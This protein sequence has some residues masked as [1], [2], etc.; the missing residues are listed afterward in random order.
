MHRYLFLLFSVFVLFLASCNNLK[1]VPEDK[2]L[3]DKVR[4]VTEKGTVKSNDLSLNLYQVPNKHFLGLFNLSLSWYN[5][6]GKDTTKFIN[7]VFRKIGRAPVI[8]DSVQTERSRMVM[9]NMLVNKGYFEA[10]IEKKVEIKNRRVYVQYLVNTNKPYLIR[11]Y[12]FIPSKDT[13]SQLIEREMSSSNIRPG[14]LLNSGKLDGERTR[15]TKKLMKEGYYVMQKDFFSYN[16]DTA[17]KSHQADVRLLLSPYLPDTSGMNLLQEDLSKYNYPVYRVRDVF[18]MLDVPMSSY[19][20]NTASGFAPT[21]RNMVFDV[22]DFDTININSY[23][24]VYRGSPFISPLALIGNCRILPGELYN[25]N[26]VEKTYSRMS[27]LQLMKYINIRFVEQGVDSLGMHQ[28][29]CYIV[30]TPNLNQA[31]SFELEGT[32]TAGDMGVAGNLNYIHRNLFKGAELFQ[33]KIRGAYEA[34]SATDFT[35]DYTEFGGELSMTLPD[36]KMPFLSTE[37]KKNV[38]ANTELT[39][40]FQ[41]MD[42]PEFERIIA[43]TG[44]HYNWMRNNLRQT[45]DLIDASYVYMPRVTDEFKAKYLNDSS[46]LKYSYEDHF[47]LRTGYSFS[48]TN[49]PIGSAN[50]AYST[51]RGSV[52]SAGNVLY[53]ICSLAGVP[54]N[55]GSYKIGNINFAQYVKG[56]IEY[57]KSDVLSPKSRLAYRFG[58]GLAYPF[59]N[60]SV[61]PFEKRFFSGGANSVRGWSVRTLGPGSYSSGS[62]RINFMNQS[63]DIKLDMGAEY[64]SSLFWKLESALFADV[65]NIWTFRKYTDQ[66]GGQFKFDTFYKQLASSIGVGLRM[67]FGFFLVRLDLGMKVFDPS[68]NGEERWRI[69][70]IDSTDDFALHFAIGYPF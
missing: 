60:S 56:E 58:L 54:K 32:N 23:H 68:L 63:G 35:S 6:S 31:T 45:F 11:K 13:I 27:S 9:Q 43:S 29:D 55:G 36:F 70:H 47:I 38:D 42:R 57:A 37:F 61:L 41:K 19:I 44:V 5:L 8:Y 28:L 39:M 62:T 1:Y 34:L 10:K 69:K 33:I 24:A 21:S 52:E 2:L 66:T 48:Y 65:G 26:N 50:G 14:M 30:L 49:V 7:R 4:I 22:A 18:F 40:S 25:V 20:R 53:A 67:D 46:Y 12:D 64:R 3:L 16:V 51:L 15:L 59:G 17:L